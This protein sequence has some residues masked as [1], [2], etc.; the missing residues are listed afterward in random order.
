[1]SLHLGKSELELVLFEFQH[2]VICYME[3]FHRHLES[4]MLALTGDPGLSAEDCIILHAIRLGDRAK[5]IPDIQHFTNRG[6][7]ANV[8]Y[9][10]KKLVKAGLARNAHK[11]ATVRGTRYELTPQGK[12]LTERY[13]Q[14]RRELIEMI[15]AEP[16]KLI[17]EL[18]KANA[19]LITLTGLYDHVSRTEAAR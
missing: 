4:Q 11:K 16:A 19:L 9:S 3:A 18:K 8:Q 2:G 13:V 10:V 17:A 6:D 5:S 12:T 15:P 1:M 14:S 7:I